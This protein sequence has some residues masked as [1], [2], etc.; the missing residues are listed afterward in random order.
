MRFLIILILSLSLMGSSIL[1]IPNSY[2]QEDTQIP[3]WIK[4][5]AGWWANDEI[6]DNTFVNAI[7]HLI[8]QGLIQV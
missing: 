7:T 4:N 6:D 3:N 1:S 2:A 5:T 8:Q